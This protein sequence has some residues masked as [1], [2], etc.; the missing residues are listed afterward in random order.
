MRQEKDLPRAAGRIPFINEIIFEK[1]PLF[2]DYSAF[3]VALV[4]LFT[5][6]NTLLDLINN[7]G[8]NVRKSPFI[9][10]RS[11]REGSL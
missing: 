5:Y 3:W 8:L 4:N 2:L 7:G 10:Q 9:R 6:N 11:C 1:Y